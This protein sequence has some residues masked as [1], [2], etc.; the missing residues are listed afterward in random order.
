MHMTDY[1]LALATLGGATK[2]RND[3][4]SVTSPK[5]AK[6][7]SMSIAR[8]YES[9]AITDFFAKKLCQCTSAFRFYFVWR[10]PR[11]QSK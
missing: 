1:I 11:Y 3:P 7:R 10:Q 4:I 9:A 2:H 5:V 8:V 6:A